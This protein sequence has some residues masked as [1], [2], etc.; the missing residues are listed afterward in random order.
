MKGSYKMTGNIWGGWV[1]YDVYVDGVYTATIKRSDP[2]E[3]T[4]LA[5]VVWNMTSEHKVKLV[6]VS[7]GV[8]FWDTLIFTP[9]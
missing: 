2:A 5:E 3:S 1:D 6:A 4:T 8:L 7:F 9:I